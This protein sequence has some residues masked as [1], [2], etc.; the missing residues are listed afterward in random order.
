MS[1][2]L[3]QKLVSFILPPRISERVVEELTLD[4]LAD[5]QTREGLPYADTSVKSLVWEL[6]YYANPRAAALA[7]ELVAEEL[8][9][10]ASEELGRPLLIPVP[11]HPARI[12]ERGHNHT[13]LLCEAALVALGDFPVKKSSGLLPP[14]GQTIFPEKSPTAFDYTPG[15]LTRIRH[16]PEQQKLSR[17]ERLVNLKNSMQASD[18]VVG[19]VCVVVDDVT[20]T[21]ATLSEAKR[22]LLEAGATKVHTLALAQS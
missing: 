10:I 1:L 12:K 22:A 13:E 17:A 5:L 16:T 18:H 2:H 6:K 4:E 21:G 20:T 19:R 15:V 7:G 9:A 8:L 3:L 14:A 11:M